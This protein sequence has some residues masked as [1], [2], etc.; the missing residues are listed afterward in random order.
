VSLARAW[1]VGG[2][3]FLV[4]T[5]IQQSA[6]VSMSI[7]LA[8]PNFLLL[9]ISLFAPYAGRTGTGA[10]GLLS[11]ILQGAIAGANLTAYSLSRILAGLAVGQLHQTELARTAWVAA[12]TA[13][14]TV[15]V[16][17][18]ILLFIAPSQNLGAFTLA[19]M[20]TAI[21]NGVLAVPLDWGLSK[22]LRPPAYDR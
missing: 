8:R 5:G 17:Q 14:L 20:G 19:T 13:F 2:V 22:V 16:A 4:A 10:L 9:A 3:F 6:A 7:G 12:L 1:L 21:Y 18:T 15:A 11:G